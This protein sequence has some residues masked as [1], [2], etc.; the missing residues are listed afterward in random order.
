MNSGT[1]LAGDDGFTIM[2]RGWLAMPAT[3][4]QQ[5]VA[6]FILYTGPICEWLSESAQRWR[7]GV[8][9]AG[10]R[11]ITVIWLTITDLG[12]QALAG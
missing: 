5:H 3:G 7:G 11:P 10:G 8:M 6:K 1:V 12:R 9:H 2:T 4:I